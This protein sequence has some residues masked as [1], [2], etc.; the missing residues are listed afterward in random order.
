MLNVAID[1]PQ[2][3]S[4]CLLPLAVTVLQVKLV[5]AEQLVPDED[6][7]YRIPEGFQSQVPL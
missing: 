1:M 7:L 6:A 5:G 4:Y 3:Y 2:A